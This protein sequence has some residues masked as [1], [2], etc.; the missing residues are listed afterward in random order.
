LLDFF[1]L[2]RLI[3]P[4][5]AI[6]IDDIS[7][8]AV[9]KAVKYIATFPCYTLA[10]SVNQRGWRRHLL[11]AGKLAISTILRPLTAA[12]GSALSSE[13][14][15][16]SLIRR[17]SILAFDYST[18]VAFQKVSEDERDATWYAYF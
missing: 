4:G 17:G 12:V 8:P 16:G 3:R 1:Y 13:F 7:M 5:G 14:L 11:N 15:E 9:N 10:G 18:M 6:V 2:N